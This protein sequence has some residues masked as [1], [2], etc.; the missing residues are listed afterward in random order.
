MNPAPLRRAAAIIAGATVLLAAPAALGGATG[1]MDVLR[2]R[3]QDRTV[4]LVG[5]APAAPLIP[6]PPAAAITAPVE[7][8]PERGPEAVA[9]LAPAARSGET[10][11]IELEPLAGELVFEPAPE[12]D[13]METIDRGDDGVTP[14]AAPFAWPRGASALAIIGTLSK[15]E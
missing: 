9:G 2:D 3:A 11:G 7:L 10:P 12:S 13:R 4:P 8:H 6:A 1:L 14:G 15:A 5:A